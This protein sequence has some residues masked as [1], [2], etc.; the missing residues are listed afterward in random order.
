[1]LQERHRLALLSEL[2]ADFHQRL[3]PLRLHRRLIPRPRFFQGDAEVMPRRRGILKLG[4]REGVAGTSDDEDAIGPFDEAEARDEHGRL[5]SARRLHDRRLAIEHLV[6]QRPRQGFEVGACAGP[7]VLPAQ[8][9]RRRRFPDARMV[10]AQGRRDFLEEGGRQLV[11]AVTQQGE[12][13]QVLHQPQRSNVRFRPGRLQQGTVN[14]PQPLRGAH[15][16][17][18]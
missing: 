6:E 10:A 11:A 4:P 12:F 13:K 16:A 3:Q 2:P 17:S 5:R 18:R 15:S 8:L 7:R 9:P 14:G 1:M